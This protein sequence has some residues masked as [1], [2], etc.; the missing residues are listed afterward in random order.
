MI[1]LAV[2]TAT[3][4]T[5]VALLDGNNTLAEKCVPA[6]NHS[7]TLLPL[8]DQLLAETKLDHSQI[9]AVGVGV[10]FRCRQQSR[11]KVRALCHLHR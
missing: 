11:P 2:D 7:R 1:L 5:T 3:P 6:K 10:W 9:Q 8:I 4:S